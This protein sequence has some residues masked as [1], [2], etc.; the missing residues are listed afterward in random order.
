MGIKDFFI[1]KLVQSKMK[2]LPKEQQEMVMALVSEN[3]EFFK[4]IEEQVSQKKKN[5]LNEQHAMMQTIRENQAELQ[6]MM[7]AWQQKKK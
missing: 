4:K 2:G 1:K 3:P 6:K 5:G 7:M